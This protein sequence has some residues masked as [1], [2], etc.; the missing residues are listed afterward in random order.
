MEREASSS[1]MLPSAAGLAAELRVARIVDSWQSL[2]ACEEGVHTLPPAHVQQYI[3]M[4]MGELRSAAALRRVDPV[5]GLHWE[6]L[7]KCVCDA[8]IMRCMLTNGVM[9]HVVDVIQYTPYESL[10]APACAAECT[11]R[12]L[13]FVDAASALHGR[14]I[15]QPCLTQPFLQAFIRLLRYACNHTH[16]VVVSPWFRTYKRMYNAHSLARRVAKD[17]DLAATMA[18]LLGTRSTPLPPSVTDAASALLQCMQQWIPR[19]QPFILQPRKKRGRAGV[20]AGSSTSP[21]R[22]R[23]HLSLDTSVSPGSTAGRALGSAH[24]STTSP[25]SPDVSLATGVHE[26]DGAKASSG[27]AREDDASPR[28]RPPHRLQRVG[29]SLLSVPTPP[30][31]ASAM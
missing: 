11:T 21:S 29:V 5:A 3:G 31:S 15:L 26:R 6:R 18:A 16:L 23:Q 2:H 24:T 30:S 8:S 20:A 7:L 22:D 27:L 17:M 19:R 1:H 12:M 25:A 4:A 9:E 10:L 14:R 28:A 13:L